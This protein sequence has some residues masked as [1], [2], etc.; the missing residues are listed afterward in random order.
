MRCPDTAATHATN[1]K[2]HESP[3]QSSNAQQHTAT[4][5]PRTQ[6]AATQCSNTLQHAATR[7]NK[8]VLPQQSSNTLQHCD[9]LQHKCVAL[10]EQQHTA[11]HM[12]RTHNASTHCNT[13]YTCVALTEQQHTSTHCNTKRDALAEYN[14]CEPVGRMKVPIL[15]N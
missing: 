14:Q 12:R 5:M 8:H 4:D 1:C 9:T 2:T 13:K 3:S 15:Q 10:R 7:C 11:T 6:R